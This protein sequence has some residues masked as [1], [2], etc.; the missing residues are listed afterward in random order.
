MNFLPST[1]ELIFH[2]L[3]SLKHLTLFGGTI[4]A[5]T[6]ARFP[7]TLEELSFDFV[8]SPGT[9]F[10]DGIR[11][12]VHLRS[13]WLH[14]NPEHTGLP[15][16][17]NVDQLVYL[18][19]VMCQPKC[20]HLNQL[21][22]FIS[23]LPSDLNS[24]DINNEGYL[25]GDLDG[26]DLCCPDKLS[27]DHFTNLTRLNFDCLNNSKSFN[28]SIF[29]ES[30]ETLDFT[31]SKL[32]T[33]FFPSKLDRLI[34]N[35]F[36]YGESLEVFLSSI[37]NLTNLTILKIEKA[38]YQREFDFGGVEFPAQLNTIHLDLGFPDE[39]NVPTNMWQPFFVFGRFPLA[40]TYF[41]LRVFS[42]TIIVDGSTGETVDLMK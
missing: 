36:S 13:L 10:T 22:N 31:S 24:L 8:E 29:P 2:N 15:A 18:E 35:L 20:I 42:C 27:L 25:R 14:I 4:N 40:L 33:G 9:E 1:S 3:S 7:E 41:H 12:P 11:M 34:I 6:I 38:G 16:I 37:T 26:Y 32:L 23:Q 5:D 21:Q 30:L 39:D 28:V 17:V 19:N